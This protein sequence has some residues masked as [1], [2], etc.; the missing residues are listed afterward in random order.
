MKPY[1]IK[2]DVTKAEISVVCHNSKISGGSSS[3]LFPLMF[4]DSAVAQN[5]WIHKDKLPLS[6]IIGMILK[7]KSVLVNFCF[8]SQDYSRGLG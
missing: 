3:D 5:F 4:A 7:I 1:L 8:S 6:S 2:D